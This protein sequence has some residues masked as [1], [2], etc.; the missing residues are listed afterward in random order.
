MVYIPY[1][2]DSSQTD[3]V[4]YEKLVTGVPPDEAAKIRRAID[5]TAP[6][7][8]GRHLET[9]EDIS[10]HAVG[11]ALIASALK[12]DADS[13]IAALLFVMYEA[14]PE[15]ADDLIGKEFGLDV[16]RLVKG[17]DRLNDLRPI[18]QNISSD[19]HAMRMQQEVLR[20]MMLAM[21][22]DIRVV[23]LRL[24]SRT[25]TLRYYAE[26]PCQAG[27]ETARA[28]LDI[29]APL[30]NR[31]GVWE[32]KWE[33]EDRCFYFL[34]P[35]AYRQIARKLDERRTERECF[36]DEAVA[37]IKKKCAAAGI[38]AQVYGRPKHIFSIWKK[39][40]AKQVPLEEV[41]DLHALRVIVDHVSQCYAVLDIVH[42]HWT[43]IVKE[44]DDYIANPKENR[45]QSLHT[46]VLADGGR[47]L[48]AQ[49]RTWKMH[50]YAE[51]GAA[52]HW[53]YKEGVRGTI[54]QDSYGSKVDLLRKLLAWRNDV[55]DTS[56]WDKEFRRAAL[57]DTIY[58]ITP[59]GR[60]VDL[61]REATP[62]D[63]AY[64]I[65]T[66]VGHRCRGA[67]ANGAL[68]ALN[69]PLV[70]GQVVEIITAKQGG[71]S[72]DWLNS[73]L[74]YLRTSSARHKIKQYFVAID[75][76]RTM[77]EGRAIVM[78]EL[79]RDVT[80]RSCINDLV[81][82]LGYA[83]ADALFL[84]AG[85]G[86][87]RHGA[88]RHVLSNSTPA[89]RQDDDSTPRKEKVEKK[90]D[91]I[92]IVGMDKLLTQLSRCCKPAPGDEIRGYV[93]RGK[94]I[95]IHRI[96]CPNFTSMERLNP[97]RVIDADWGDAAATAVYAVDVV[98][99]CADRTGLL[100]D[101]T[102][103]LAHASI[104]VAAANAISRQDSA[105]LNLT[106]DVTGTDQLQHALQLICNIPSVQNV[107]RV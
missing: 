48:E 93:T 84:A 99:E 63:F 29:Y 72:R 67:K 69:K 70:S 77:A 86:E 1:S 22:D 104:G 33:I 50:E 13:R 78:K 35:D 90:H 96:R 40:C 47:P 5:F 64:R 44:Y 11:T 12:L 81:T 80:A 18:S 52:S 36:V 68:I 65:H 15:N 92:L 24:A 102:E 60:V 98:A 87:L 2:L 62:L 82:K 32:I 21:S 106:L 38:K 94:G 101:V 89:P 53:L 95:S 20:K 55:A 97:E 19:K 61:P 23:L 79:Q 39:M 71:P 45:Y 3:S 4:S 6:F 56:N 105:F 8:N 7:Y 37:M 83:N 14:C 91:S 74:G 34:N 46:A 16:G 103:A 107:R 43:P 17:L 100:Q 54:G 76:S 30:A 85:R 66:Y 9:G 31:L 42:Q 57:D 73:Q 59:L 49:I 51:R 58:V 75:E 26:H 27:I 28:S 10:R 41:Y 25:Q 88:I